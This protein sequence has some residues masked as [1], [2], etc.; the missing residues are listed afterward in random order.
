M[1]KLLSKIKNRTVLQ[2]QFYFFV[3][4]SIKINKITKNK[5]KII[6]LC[7]KQNKCNQLNFNY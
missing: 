6:Q 4:R 7:R 3:I 1:L 5:K 2:I